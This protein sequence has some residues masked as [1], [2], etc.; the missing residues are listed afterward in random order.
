MASV[1]IVSDEVAAG[2]TLKYYGATAPARVYV[3]DD[4]FS[5]MVIDTKDGDKRYTFEYILDE[6]RMILRRRMDGFYDGNI[7]PDIVIWQR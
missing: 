1:T 6:D 3:R 5:V 2:F 4:S 7:L